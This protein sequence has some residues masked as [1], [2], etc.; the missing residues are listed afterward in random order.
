MLN[1]M[2]D[3]GCVSTVFSLCLPPAGDMPHTHS[4]YVNHTPLFR[5]LSPI[6]LSHAHTHTHTHTGCLKSSELLLLIPPTWEKNCSVWTV[7]DECPE[8]EFRW[9]T[10]RCDYQL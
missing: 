8:W 6:I 10:T 4:V 3:R 5:G 7:I 2:K 1:T 9:Q